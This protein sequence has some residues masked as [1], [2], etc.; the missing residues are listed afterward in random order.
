MA[1]AEA[2]ACGMHLWSFIAQYTK[3]QPQLPRCM[4]NIINGG[5]HANNGLGVQEVMVVPEHACS[6][7]YHIRT[8]AAVYHSLKK[9]FLALANQPVLQMR[10]ALRHCFQGQEESSLKEH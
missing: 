10:V 7:A 8:I 4:A 9:Y 6:M 3:S 5:A 2:R 1:R